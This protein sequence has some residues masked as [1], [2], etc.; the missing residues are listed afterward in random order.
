MRGAILR[1][2]YFSTM[3]LAGDNCEG[4]REYPVFLFVLELNFL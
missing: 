2:I 4:K 1:A 3:R